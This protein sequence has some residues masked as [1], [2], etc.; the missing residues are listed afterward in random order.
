MAIVGNRLSGGRIFMVLAAAALTSSV[1]ARA[2]TPLPM[3]DDPVAAVVSAPV[4]ETTP[5]VAP[6][7]PPVVEAE[8]DHEPYGEGTASYYGHELAGNRTAS[9]ERFDPYAMTAAHRTLPMGAKL[10]VINAANGKSVVVR[11]NDRGPFA[12]N[13][14]LDVSLGAAQKIAMVRAGTAKVKLQLLR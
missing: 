8:P 5:L 11:I 7:A 4:L 9:G 3:S 12:K 1:P 2:D 10:R 14:I 6:I 13:R